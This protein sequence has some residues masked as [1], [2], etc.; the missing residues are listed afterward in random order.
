MFFDVAAV[1][2]AVRPD[3]NLSI[4]ANVSSGFFNEIELLG[5]HS[6]LLLCICHSSFSESK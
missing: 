1:A 6:D 4:H 3:I 2:S 5:F